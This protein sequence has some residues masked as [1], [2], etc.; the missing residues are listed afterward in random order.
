MS[1]FFA[2][3]SDS[4]TSSSDEDLYSSSSASGES[5]EEESSE[6]ESSE[7]ESDSDES[8]SEDDDKKK[9]ASFFLKKKFLKTEASDESDSEDDESKRVVKS[10][11]DKL[12]DELDTAIKA[13]DNAKKI[14]DWVVISNEFDKLNKHVEK[15]IKQYSTTPNQYIKALVELEDF[16]QSSIAADKAAKKKMNALNARAMNTAK[17]RIKKNNKA[18]ESLISKYREDPEGFGKA[19]SK[20]AAVAAA[21]PSKTFKTKTVSA[22]AESA[23]NDNDGFSTVGKAG[24][25][26]QYTSENIFTTIQSIAESRGKKNTDRQDQVRILEAL[27][28][29]ATTPYQKIIIYMRLIPVRSDTTSSHPTSVEN[30]KIAQNDIISLFELLEENINKYHISESA[31]EP[32]NL[33]EG[34]PPRADGIVEIP[35]SIV[36]IVERLDDEFTRALQDINHHTTEYV[37]RL[38]DE[39]SLYA[40]IL[41][42]QIYLENITSRPIHEV[43]AVSRIIIRRIDHFY[44]KPGALISKA[45]VNTWTEIPKGL[46]S[47]I[48]PRV[49]SEDDVDTIDLINRLCAVLY[50]QTNPI[51]RTKAILYNTFHYALNNQYYK[52][53]DLLLMSHLQST[54]HTAEAPVQILFNRALVQIGLCAFRNGL[55]NECQ[56]SLQ[57][58]N[59][60]AR[61][62]ELLGQGAQKYTQSTS[63]DRQKLL[64]FHMH[65][66]LELLECVYL[67]ASLLIEI[68]NIAA[69]ETHINSKK[70]TISK[71]FRRMLDNSR[72]QVFTGPPENTRDHIMQAA[73]ALLDSEWT[74]AR[75]LLNSIKI[76]NLLSDADSIKNM[77]GEKLQVEGLRTYLFK[78]GPIYQSLSIKT[79]STLFDLTEAR[80]YAIVGKLIANEE[81]FA[82]L[83]QRANSIVFRQGVEHSKLQTLALELAEKAVQLVERNE[84][85]AAGGY[86][87]GETGKT[88]PSAN[89]ANSATSNANNNNISN[90]GQSRRNQGTAKKA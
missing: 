31:P 86:P 27:L 34:L 59:A 79:L 42:S 78:F 14:N 13:I 16:L 51:Y 85:L 11:K 28:Q 20:P 33:E 54:I 24:R 30:W 50:R 52:A 76:W 21:S 47:K 61:L 60:S 19:Q 22:Q 56:Q 84:R 45:E 23:E 66:N 3:S 36:S 69:A 62:R 87:L 90:S 46:N 48:T 82:A 72:R 7:E 44:F 49:L 26:A 6:E 17:Q 2:G 73:R 9:G 38:R 71:S 74:T 32:E 64:P 37:E 57:E 29:V 65:I 18:Y 4:D 89:S 81:I 68:P 58:L 83:D 40:L 43:P 70:K 15:A 8:D 67:T 80:V 1:R 25:V 41:R 35:G 39:T 12:I 75:D 10:A 5:S 77:L 53:R 63:E 55:I 88:G